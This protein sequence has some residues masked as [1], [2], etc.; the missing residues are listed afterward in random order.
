MPYS[1]LAHFKVRDWDDSQERWRRVRKYL[2]K[3]FSIVNWT[4]SG[5]DYN[6]EI[7]DTLV[8]RILRLEDTC[9]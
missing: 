2:R 8:I 6:P 5:M 7:K 9:L 4:I 3:L 1:K